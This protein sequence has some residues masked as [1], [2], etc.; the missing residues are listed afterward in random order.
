M[1]LSSHPSSLPLSSSAV[2]TPTRTPV[3]P[4]LRRLRWLRCSGGA[5][6]AAGLVVALVGP[7]ASD[8]PDG[9]QSSPAPTR[10]AARP[11]FALPGA[12]IAAARSAAQLATAL[13]ELA[14]E[15]R[16]PSYRLPVDGPVVRPFEP[17]AGA[18]GP[19]H[20]GVDLDAAPGTPVRPPSA[21]ASHHA[22]QVAGIVW[23]SI[24][25]RDGVRTSYGPLA[26]LRGPR[27][28]T[29]VER[30]A[31]L[32]L[33]ADAHHGD[34]DVDRGLHWGARRD[35]A[36]VDPMRL[37]GLGLPRPTLVGEGGWW[38]ADHAVTPYD[39]WG[40]GRLGGVLTTPSP[41]RGRTGL[42]GPAEPEPP[43]ARRRA[44]EHERRRADRPRAP[45]HRRRRARRG[46]PTPAGP[47]CLRRRGDL[48][49]RRVARRGGSRSS[50]ES[51]RG[52]SR[53]VRST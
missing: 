52:G 33:L 11:A 53:V 38:G 29:T 39:P 9:T 22:G 43:R 2:S 28:A 5:A 23:V 1:P 18:Y 19:G 15:L 4:R 20:R 36:Y 41:T 25:H 50:C 7:A 42:R 17:P 13:S 49:G 51:R 8:V 48:A 27:R 37:P 47:G 26:A 14:D 24:D 34:G 31:V 3:R 32:G 40:G 45:R 46:S 10:A 30:G 16:P 44:V 35:G 12:T 21:V 6:L